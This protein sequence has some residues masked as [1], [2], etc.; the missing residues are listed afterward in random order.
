MID[1]PEAVSVG[2]VV[3]I[4]VLAALALVVFGLVRF[5]WE[6][7]HD[8]IELEPGGSWGDEIIGDDPPPPDDK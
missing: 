4:V 8:E 2:W 6:F 5:W 1:L 3:L 7:D